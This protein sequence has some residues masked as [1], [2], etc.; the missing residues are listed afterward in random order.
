MSFTG[1]TC[2][3]GIVFISFI[4]LENV[5]VGSLASYLFEKKFS[6]LSSLLL[7][8][9]VVIS[10]VLCFWFFGLAFCPK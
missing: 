1:V 7:L 2:M 3:F 6:S 8:F 10:F 4:S 9:L 5:N